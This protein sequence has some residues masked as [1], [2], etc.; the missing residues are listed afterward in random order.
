MIG[1]M[2]RSVVLTVIVLVLGA[3]GVVALLVML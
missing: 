2:V 3:A 1:G